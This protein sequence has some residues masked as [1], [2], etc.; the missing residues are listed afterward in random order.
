M[1]KLFT[2][3][4][5]AFA[6]LTINATNLTVA[7][8]YERGMALDSLATDSVAITVEGY[9]YGVGPYSL[10]YNNQTY[11]L[12]DDAANTAKIELEAYQ[13]GAKNGNDTVRVLEG[14]KVALTGK[15][16]KFY[17]KKA[18]KFI[19]EI[20]KGT[21]TIV[22]AAEGD[23]AIDRTVNE[24]SIDSA[25]VIGAKLASGD[26][27]PVNYAIEGF[28]VG[29]INDKDNTYSD[30]GWAKYKNQ[31]V[32]IS[33]TENGTAD[34]DHAFE[35]YQGIGKADGESVE[36]KVGHKVRIVCQIKNYNGTV[37]NADTKI[38]V[39]VLNYVEEKIDTLT[40]AEAATIALGLADNAISEKTYAVVGTVKKIKNEFNKQYSNESFYIV[41]QYP[42]EEGAL[43]IQ[44][45]RAKIAE[46]GCEVGDRV[47]VTG[48]LK[49]N[50]HDDIHTAELT[51]G[52]EAKILWHAGIE[53]V[54]L[55]V[56]AQK[57]M[58]DGVVYIV[59]DNKMFDLMGNQVR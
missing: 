46:P 51:E 32:W 4:A 59:R 6:A 29:F 24:V 30:G 53:E 38:P 23:R 27:T 48:K 42:A 50:T 18:K 43:D 28:V 49:N 36:M 52:S 41:D 37:E 14:D 2:F 11:F 31:S 3:V 8:A 40:V 9:A 20:S 7:Q 13:C 17:D 21:A 12:S 16:Y 54:T 58:V 44:C 26:Q 19:I 57:V 35:I 10:F 56:K 39:Q 22:T 34:K 15:L 47:I 45:Y 55:T 1:K 25:L 5:A 33:A